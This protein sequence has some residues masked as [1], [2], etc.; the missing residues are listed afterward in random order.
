[1]QDGEE[2]EE[3]D[4]AR[5]RSARADDGVRSAHGCPKCI[6]GC[7]RWARARRRCGVHA[8]TTAPEDL[9][10]GAQD[11]EEGEEED[12]A[13]LAPRTR[14]CTSE[15]EHLS[16]G[17]L[18]A[19]GLE[20]NARQQQHQQREAAAKAAAQAAA[21]GPAQA[22]QAADPSWLSSERYLAAREA[23]AAARAAARGSSSSASSSASEPVPALGR[24]GGEMSRMF[25]DVRPILPRGA[26]SRTADALAGHIADLQAQ[27]AAFTAWVQ[28][29]YSCA[30]PVN[31]NPVFPATACVSVA[32]LT[33]WVNPGS[34]YR[35]G[36]STRE[37]P[38]G[39]GRRTKGL[40]STQTFVAGQQTA[41]LCCTKARR[42]S[43]GSWASSTP[44]C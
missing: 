23:A 11:G 15:R 35:C 7:G 31:P 24:C 4:G 36:R 25:H 37:Q 17:S 3:E 10:A 26:H 20:R 42:S 27:H 29:R 18:A 44:S 12:G 41:R 2:E 28:E 14:N 16:G 13:A 22:A 19:R 1:M 33:P 8:N 40:K 21:Q 39:Y 5:G 34:R 32:L 30:R 38:V 9:Q 6:F 43:L